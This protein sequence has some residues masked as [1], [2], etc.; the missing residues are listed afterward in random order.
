M[1]Q[2]AEHKRAV[3]VVIPKRHHHLVALLGNENEAAVGGYLVA[4]PCVGS[5]YPYPRGLHAAGLPAHPDL[6]ATEMLG[7]VVA[8][9]SGLLRL[10]YR[11]GNVGAGKRRD[12]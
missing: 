6:D 12:G 11:E 4:N 10:R 8:D 7:V 3:G 5:E 1:E 9:D 2:A